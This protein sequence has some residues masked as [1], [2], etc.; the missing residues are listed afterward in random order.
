MKVV[1]VE[2]GSAVATYPT[3]DAALGDPPP[4]AVAH[5]VVHGGSRTSAVRIDADVLRA[6]HE[7]TDLAPLHQ[8]PAIAAIEQCMAAW[9][10][11]ANVAC[12]DTAFHATLPEAARTYALPARYRDVVRV[13]GFHGVSYA[14]ATARVAA[15]APE[16]RRLL[17]A[18]L[19][20]GQS[21]CAVRDGQSVM[22][23]MGFT[24]LDGLVMATRSGTVDPGAVLWLQR[25]A[26]EDL[27]HMLEHESGL[28]GLSGTGD[29]RELHARADD[30]A[31]LAFNV[32]LH[33]IVTEMGACVAALGGID[34]LVFTGG[35]GEH[36]RVARASVAAAFEWLG[37]RVAAAEVVDDDC[38][39]TAPGATVRSFVI[40]A[41]EDLQL[42][43]ET[44][45]VLGG[46]P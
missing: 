2:N 36:D 27:E 29:M 42:A 1:V 14:W 30:N 15:R 22:T 38:E 23:T 37:V 13:Y 40:Q 10:A 19:G 6:L 12:F 16:L 3:L 7:L 24:P 21:L 4:D 39:I 8:P 20:G 11:V 45:E 18:H 5:R 9:P 31:R 41:R 26:D 46:A 17:I 35:I 44:T 33:R 43:A 32:W 34:G 25:H 28:F